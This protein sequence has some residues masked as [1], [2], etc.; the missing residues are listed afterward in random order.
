MDLVQSLFQT[1]QALAQRDDEQGGGFDAL[2]SSVDAV[3]A[4]LQEARPGDPA[5]A[6]EGAD[7]IDRTLPGAEHEADRVRA[8]LMAFADRP[9]AE[10]ATHAREALD[11][12]HG[13]MTG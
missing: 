1:K 9:T 4:Q 10:N 11:A 12:L 5:Y 13:T 7:R 3:L 6:E 8:A 2:A